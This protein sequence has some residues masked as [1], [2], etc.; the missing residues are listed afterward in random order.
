MSAMITDFSAGPALDAERI[1]EF[2]GRLFQ[3]YTGGMVTFMIDLAHRTG[4]FDAMT[5]GPGTS[6]E[7]AER[8][9]L[10]ERYVRECLGAL[11]TA[12]IVEY[13]SSAATYSLPAEHAVCLTGEG[14]M[15]LAPMSLAAT[16]AAKN[17]EGVA[18]AF[19]EGGGVPYEKFRPEFTS[20]MDGMSRG[21]MDGQLL[22]GI[23]PLVDGLTDRLTS[24]VRAADVGCGTGH[25]INLMARAYPDSHFVGF[26]IADDA[27]DAARREASDY[28]LANA[29]FEVVDATQLPVEP[30][31][32]V[33]FAFDS[34]H[35]QVDPAGVLR[36]IHDALASDGVFV[37]MDI[38]AN[39]A[40]EDNVGNP[41]A[42]FLYS[43]ST[44]HCL[45]VSLAHGGAG[46]GTV[47]G[48]QLAKQMLTDAGFASTEVFD[49]PD[50][51]MDSVYVARAS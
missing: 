51:P 21:L 6:M 15:N 5:S 26:D 4:L 17:V 16:L 47:W 3:T 24:G 50:D 1:D 19:R 10:Q 8:A 27:I 18:T 25:A 30:P 44:L 11:V 46:L 42:P 48:E 35:D 14:S 45:T 33:I 2:M 49:V 39:S 34:I 20:V 22:E 36:R 9:G 31:F 38:K 29:A 40:L 12:D 43:I 23:L 37:M 13:E 28:D 32:D 41:F 7:L